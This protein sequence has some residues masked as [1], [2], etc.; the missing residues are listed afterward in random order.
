[1]H[2]QHD[3]QQLHAVLG[4]GA[5]RSSLTALRDDYEKNFKYEGKV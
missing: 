5:R 1:M 3:L 2:A 4:E